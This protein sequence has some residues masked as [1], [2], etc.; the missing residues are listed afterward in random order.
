MGATAKL[1]EGHCYAGSDYNRAKKNACSM[2]VEVEYMPQGED[3]RASP[4]LDK[5]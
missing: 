2:Q 4:S 5:M 3:D 1:V